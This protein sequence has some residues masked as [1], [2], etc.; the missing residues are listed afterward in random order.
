MHP[1]DIDIPLFTKMIY[2]YINICVIHAVTKG[3]E[4]LIILK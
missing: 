1:I 3:L 4:L 2:A